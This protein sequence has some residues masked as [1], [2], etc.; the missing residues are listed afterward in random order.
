ME[1]KTIENI[2]DEDVEH[3]LLSEVPLS[4]AKGNM[5]MPLR[6]EKAASLPL[7]L[8]TGECLH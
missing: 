8:M 2:R 3:P 4:F 1:I 5:I 7:L 6:R